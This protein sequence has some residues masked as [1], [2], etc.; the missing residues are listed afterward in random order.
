MTRAMAV[1]VLYNFD[2]EAV[3]GDGS[4]FTD[5]DTA[6]WFCSAIGWAYESGVSNGY[7]DSY[8][9]M[10]QVTRQDLVTMLYNYAKMIGYDVSAKASVSAF[11][12]AGDVSDY[13]LEAMEW[14]LGAGLI[15]GVTDQTLSPTSSTTR[16]Q[17]AT[18]IM[19]FISNVR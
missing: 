8:G 10:D 13:A 14:A 6:D 12:D 1:Q 4:S 7:G 17:V 19:R 18:I 15:K 3:G 9:V 11:G 5:V 2:R 16:A